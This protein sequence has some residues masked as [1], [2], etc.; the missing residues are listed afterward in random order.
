MINLKEYASKYVYE[1]ILDDIDDQLDAGDAYMD[2][3]RAKKWSE[4]SRRTAKVKRQ[5]AGYAMKGDFKI[6]DISQKEYDGYPIKNIDGNLSI[7]GCELESLKG[8]FLPYCEITGSLTIED[9]PNFM[10]LEG[11][12][13]SVG[14]LAI[15]GNPKFKSLE[16]CPIVKGNMYLSHNGKKFDLN[17]LKSDE[18]I[19][20]MKRIFCSAE[21]DYEIIGESQINEAFKAPQ[22]VHL[23][24]EIKKVS[25]KNREL[26]PHLTEILNSVRLDSIKSSDVTELDVKDPDA[27]KYAKLYFSRKRRGFF[28]CMDSEGNIGPIFR[29]DT[30]LNLDGYR[31]NDRWS[32]KLNIYTRGSY[33]RQMDM[34]RIIS[35]YDTIV[36]V[37][38]NDVELTNSIKT[39]RR[40]SRYGAVAMQRGYERSG[41]TTDI[42]AYDHID[43]KQ[44]RYYQ[45][46]A[47]DNR[48]RYKSMLVKLK[49]ERAANVNTFGKYK[50]QVDE[51]FDR[52]TAIVEKMLLNPTKYSSWELDALNRAFS[53]KDRYEQSI[54]NTLTKYFDILRDAS[55]GYSYGEGA[56]ITDKVKKFQE[57]LE[58]S[59]KHT[60]EV[61]KEL[62]NK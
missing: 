49:A 27:G 6:D 31:S 17:K 55:R 9:C 13:K 51:L 11:A 25:E 38:T 24:N 61:L 50:K 35:R 41:N 5:K 39:D 12:P 52:Y 59:I 28:Y 34:L 23:A 48:Q 46:I 7:I 45:E 30:V 54:M 26:K 60:D 22:L 2:N 1:G 58:A 42:W 3:E 62:E 53:T 43:A 33:I 19:I 44:V 20:V 56:N 32:S 47:E 37:D 29:G 8:M 36:F 57:D 18:N 4:K 10:S 16:F 40:N 14:S 15:S 21:N